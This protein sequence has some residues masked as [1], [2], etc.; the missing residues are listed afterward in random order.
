[1]IFHPKR[2]STVCNPD[3]AICHDLFRCPCCV[4]AYQRQEHDIRD[5][6]EASEIVS[7]QYNASR[8]PEKSELNYSPDNRD[9]SAS[10]HDEETST[11]GI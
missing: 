10:G 1:M 11:N 5:I 7:K 4:G 6:V 8:T 9:E 2:T 3:N